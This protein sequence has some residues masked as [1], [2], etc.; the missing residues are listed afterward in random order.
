MRIL[1]YVVLATIF[2]AIGDA[3]MRVA[4]RSPYALTGRIAL[5]AVASFLL[6]IVRIIFES[7]SGR[8]RDCDRNLSRV[9]VRC[10]SDSEFYL[11]PARSVV[12]RIHRRNFHPYWYSDCL[13]LEMTILRHLFIS[14][15]PLRT[16]IQRRCNSA[17]DW[18]TSSATV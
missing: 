10:I 5:F 18:S 14:M 13:L 4:L 17:V 12:G 8:V 11:L 16:R 1:V 15:S 2:E 6:T 9:V 3:V 7:C